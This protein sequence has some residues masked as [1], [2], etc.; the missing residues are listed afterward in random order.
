MILLED[1]ILELQP[2]SDE[3]VN[4][5]KTHKEFFRALKQIYPE[6]FVSPAMIITSYPASGDE[7]I[8]MFTFHH[9]LKK[10]VFKQDF[11]VNT[12]KLNTEFILYTRNP[13]GSSKY[14]KD[15]NDFFNKFDKYGYKK[16]D[17]H[18]SLEELPTQLHERARNAVELSRKLKIGSPQKIPQK[19]VDRIYNEVML[20]K[21]RNRT[22]KEKLNDSI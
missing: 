14:V 2:F 3:L 13:S 12:G 20:I 7:V 19:L 21:R 22:D 9:Q 1:V 6:R 15:I 8:G 18:L 4:W 16:S 10:P 5:C 17:H 11:I